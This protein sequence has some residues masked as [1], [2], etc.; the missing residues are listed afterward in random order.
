DL[1]L[2]TLASG[3]AWSKFRAICEAQGGLRR[4]P[5]A[6]YV[7]PL[8]AGRTGRAIHIDNRKLA[9]LAK[10]ARAPEANAAGVHLA[11]RLGDGI[12]R[13]QPLLH[14][15]AETAGELAYALDYAA[16]AGDIIEVET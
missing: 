13:G 1:A 5:K 9:R 11:V 14:V 7:H 10:L 6:S 8:V 16:G 3:R 4:P 2:E 12:D 15:H